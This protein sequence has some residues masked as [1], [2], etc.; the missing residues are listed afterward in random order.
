MWRGFVTIAFQIKVSTFLT[1]SIAS[2]VNIGVNISIIICSNII[3]SSNNI[4]GSIAIGRNSSSG[5]S[6]NNNNNTNNNGSN[7]NN[8]TTTN[9]STINKMNAFIRLIW[10]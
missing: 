1:H 7:N 8:R 5:N 2:I 10:S 6:N 3:S 9:I 4:T